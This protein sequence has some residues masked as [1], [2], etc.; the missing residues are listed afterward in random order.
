MSEMTSSVFLKLRDELSRPAHRAA[1][2]VKSLVKD[3]EKLKGLSG[4]SFGGAN[5]QIAA[6]TRDV[7][8]A[9]EAT[10]SLRT[11]MAKPPTEGYA[12]AARSISRVTSEADKASRAVRGLNRSLQG[13][14]SVRS[15]GGSRGGHGGSGARGGHGGFGAAG[16]FGRHVAR[17]ALGTA[18]GLG[19]Y[20]VGSEIGEGIGEAI[21][22]GM[23]QSFD[24]AHTK[25][26]LWMQGEKLGDI[27]AAVAQAGKMA[28]ILP[29]FTS[30]Q[31]LEAI[32]ELRPALQ[33][34]L[35]EAISIAP[36][37]QQAVGVLEAV[38]QGAGE[39]ALKGVNAHG[40]ALDMVR[41]LEIGGL[42]SHK[43][44][45]SEKIENNM[46]AMVD[47][48][49]KAIV[50]FNGQI[51]AK[52]F[53]SGFKFSR[54]LAANWTPEFATQIF[55]TLMNELKKSSKTDASQAGNALQSMSNVVLD[56]VM[57]PAAA[58]KWNALHMFEDGTVQVGKKGKVQTNANFDG[59]IG[60]EMF[61][62]NPYQWVQD[63][64]LPHL[65]QY[66]HVDLNDHAAVAASLSGL[67]GNR[68]AKQIVAIMAT[69]QA[70][71]E[72]DADN[73]RRARGA[74]GL[75]ELLNMD[76]TARMQVFA[77]SLKEL[78]GAV[79]DLALPGNMRAMKGIIEWAHNTSDAVRKSSTWKAI[80]RHYEEVVAGFFHQGLDGPRGR[81]KDAKA[82]YADGTAIRSAVGNIKKLV[83]D[84]AAALAPVGGMH[85]NIQALA[86]WIDGITKAFEAELAFEKDPLGFIESHIQANEQS[87]KD[88][89]KQ[90]QDAQDAPKKAAENAARDA[91]AANARK[92]YQD[93]QPLIKVP[94]MVSPAHAKK[95]GLV[96]N[97][98]GSIPSRQNILAT[99]G[100]DAIADANGRA[101]AAAPT[102]RAAGVSLVTAMAAGI[103]SGG[104]AATGGMSAL[105]ASLATIASKGVEVD[106]RLN[107]AGA[108]AQLSSLMAKATTLGKMKP[109]ADGRFSGVLFDHG[110]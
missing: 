85:E 68:V 7:K 88:A 72:K 21:K 107:T 106:V 91:A 29:Q 9:T 51:G 2:S 87:Y 86:A 4:K 56:G 73:V 59:L 47:G 17:H 70:Q 105:M 50:A 25:S 44:W 39:S 32:A 30:A 76:P 55:P 63:T 14:G 19:L 104:G 22:A 27:N 66:N 97:P 109:G 79:G 61:Q 83:L 12:R 48:M 58:A 40:E 11:S 42:T 98:F 23:E 110:Q 15:G 57:R 92:I 71:I 38:K 5:K 28:R 102:M 34:G 80:G 6:L 3:L 53:H 100:G 96:H 84:F 108:E 35:K 78:G 74:S 60:H 101:T 18:A 1:E 67:F 103:S 10:K 75:Q 36:M 31:H 65:Q 81:G 33:G 16:H 43:G 64:L 46:A 45:S 62:A 26:M 24:R 89:R 20:A 52:D 94:P 13:G 37:I 82:F 49:T 99:S 77:A 90:A 95:M 69:Q 41:A 93:A 8:K 54:G